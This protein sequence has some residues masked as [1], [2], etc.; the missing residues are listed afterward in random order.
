MA[1]SLSMI[2]FEIGRVHI[3]FSSLLVCMMLAT[4]FCNICDFSLEIMDRTD[5]WT[6]PLFIIFFVI[7]GA[8]LELSVFSDPVIIFIG[9]VYIVFRSL[10]KY[11][12]AG[13]SSS[14]MKCEPQVRANLG[15]TLLPQ[16]GV[17]LGMASTVGALGPH[18]EIVRNIVLFG[19]MIYELVG[20]SLTKWALGRA[21]EIDPKE[22]G[23][24]ARKIPENAGRRK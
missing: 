14:F 17:A 4:V 22:E 24:T 12:G 19:V 5:K 6:Y 1:V 20:P 23:K 10:G 2:K 3:G 7:S 13:W 11:F 21:G 8:E 15:I 18:G 16:A 9:V